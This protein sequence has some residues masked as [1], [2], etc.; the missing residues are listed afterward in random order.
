[1][2]GFPDTWLD[3][4]MLTEYLEADALGTKQQWLDSLKDRACQQHQWR[5]QFQPP[6]MQTATSS[7]N[8]WQSNPGTVTVMQL[9]V[10]PSAEVYL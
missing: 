2:D 4:M 7:S 10:H 9:W 1:M 8:S 6:N 5:A 3:G